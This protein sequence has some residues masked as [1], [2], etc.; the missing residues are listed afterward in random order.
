MTTENKLLALDVRPL[1]FTH[2]R[3][4]Y[5][6]WILWILF[7]I[8]LCIYQVSTDHRRTVTAAFHN[9]ASKWI[10]GGDMYGEGLHGFLYLPH[11]AIAYTPFHVLP[12]TPSE[13]LWRAFCIGLFAIGVRQLASA[14]G[15]AAKVE[16]FPI[17]TFFTIPL[18]LSA[19]RNGQMTLPMAGAMMISIG[20]LV[21]A[22]YW[23]AVFWLCLAVALKPLAVVLL[24]LA[25]ALRPGLWWRMPIG[26]L[27]LLAVP[28]LFQSHAYVVEAYQGF[29]EKSMTSGNPEGSMSYSDL[30]GMFRAWGMEGPTSV[31]LLIRF[32]FAVLTLGLAFYIIRRHG[33]IYGITMLFVL[34]MTY[35][36]LFNPR[37]ENN[38][39]AA[40][41]PALAAI[42]TWAFLIG[43]Q[44]TLGWCLVIMLLLMSVNYELTKHITPGREIWLPPLLTILFSIYLIWAML[45]GP[46]PWQLRRTRLGTQSIT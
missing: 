23:W 7:F 26:I 42:G 37:T 45:I 24:L 22:R 8:G 33:P 2:K 19:M 38:T 6:A 17:M 40:F 4:V 10:E 3:D 18:S 34:A 31:S 32:V 41:A 16:L 44:S 11:A 43:K 14:A 5:G 21:Q 12:H 27:I 35:L 13:L 39:Y 36:M 25:W 9:G 46:A 15:K 30:F 1:P 28:W 29:V 20:A